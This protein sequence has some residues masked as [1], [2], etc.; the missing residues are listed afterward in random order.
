MADSQSYREMGFT[1]AVAAGV[2][3]YIKQALNRGAAC[4]ALATGR[5]R[6]KLVITYES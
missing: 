4:D 5:T 2:H 6:S 3:P 1:E